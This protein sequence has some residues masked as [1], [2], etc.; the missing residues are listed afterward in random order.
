M[1]STDFNSAVT[2]GYGAK[3]I[4]NA[5]V[6]SPDSV[7]T[8]NEAGH[9]PVYFSDPRTA[10]GASPAVPV[11]GEL[12]KAGGSAA[13]RFVLGVCN[14]LGEGWQASWLPQALRIDTLSARSRQVLS[15]Y[16]ARMQD[17]PAVSSGLA[18][19]P[20]ACALAFLPAAQIGLLSVY[21]GAMTMQDEVRCAIGK[22]EVAAYR[23]ALEEDLYAFVVQRA[24]LLGGFAATGSTPFS[25]RRSGPETIRRD[26]GV[27]GAAVLRCL[28]RSHDGVWQRLRLKLPRAQVLACEVIP[29]DAFLEEDVRKM[30]SRLL[31]ELQPT[32]YQ[33][34]MSTHKRHENRK[35]H[36]S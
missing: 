19:D 8:T 10:N 25:M 23:M 16:V 29:P 15:A 4:G 5:I 22:T 9:A 12:W 13:C 30:A 26:I 35:N 31:R 1:E 2:P 34:W 14:E 3:E 28:F 20:L 36:S 6:T 21:L 11:S 7:V 27:A 33:R 17:L 24:S 32:I 18:S